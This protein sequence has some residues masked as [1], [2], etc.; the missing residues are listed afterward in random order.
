M[1]VVVVIVGTLFLLSET[2]YMNLLF[3]AL[4]INFVL[5]LDRLLYRNLVHPQT[6]EE[7]EGIQPVAVSTHILCPSMNRDTCDILWA[8]ALAALTTEQ[9]QSKEHRAANAKRH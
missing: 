8:V 3:D 5:E 4:S 7:F 2:S 1:L 9:T 6:Q